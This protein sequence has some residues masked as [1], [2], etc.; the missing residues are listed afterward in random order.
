M[1]V[2]I[3]E[4]NKYIPVIRGT[5]ANVTPVLRIPAVNMMSLTL[6]ERPAFS[7]TPLGGVCVVNTNKKVCLPA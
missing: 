5:N 3:F 6:E 7:T 1:Y 4:I 2:V